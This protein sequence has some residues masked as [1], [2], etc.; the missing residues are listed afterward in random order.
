MSANPNGESSK[1]VIGAIRGW[2]NIPEANN[3]RGIIDEMRIWNRV[4]TDKE[5]TKNMRVSKDEFLSIE[6]I[7]GLAT[8]WGKIKHE[9]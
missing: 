5:I 3:W 9:F 8:Q 2:G 7:I 1:I 6:P 4:L